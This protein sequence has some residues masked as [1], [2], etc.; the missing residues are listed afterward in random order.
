[1]SALFQ[2]IIKECGATHLGTNIHPF[3]GGGITGVAL[4]G[5]SHISVHT[6]PEN[7]FA[8]FDIFM[9]KGHKPELAIDVLT[10]VLKPKHK[11]VNI[12]RRGIYN[13]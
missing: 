3:D 12:L 10:E 9:C 4:L 2:R 6:W 1:M 13:D 8:A 11:H 7:N 5:E